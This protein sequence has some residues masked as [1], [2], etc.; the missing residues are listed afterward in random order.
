MTK[1]IPGTAI[2]V[3]KIVG[4]CIVTAA[5]AEVGFLGGRMLQDDIETTVKVV[6]SKVNPTVM[7]RRKWY[8]KPEKFN[9]RTQKFVADMKR[10]KKSN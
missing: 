3:A 4:S 5:I 6:D 1:N 2:K 7:K 8:K 9:T 10:T